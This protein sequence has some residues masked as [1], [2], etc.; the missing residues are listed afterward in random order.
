MVKLGLVKRECVA[1]SIHITVR[2]IAILMA[3]KKRLKQT[4]GFLNLTKNGKT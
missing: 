2:C 3:N 1:T 4:L